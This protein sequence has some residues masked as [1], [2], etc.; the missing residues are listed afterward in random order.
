VVW[1]S[2]LTAAANAALT[3]AQ[4]NASV[5]DNLNETAVAKATTAGYHFASN[6]TNSIAERAVVVANVDTSETTTNTS[7]TDLATPGPTTASI[8]TGPK[9]LIWINASVSNSAAAQ[10]RASYGVSG[11]STLAPALSLAVVGE[12][13]AGGANPR[14][15]VCDLRTITAGSNAFYMQYTVTAGTGTFANRRIVVMGL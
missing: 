1:T 4:W 2:P 13:T 3:A 6:G 14:Q 11:A 15:G 12:Q 10:S 9:A 5:R 7:F 8:T